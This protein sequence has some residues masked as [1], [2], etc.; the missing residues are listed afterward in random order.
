MKVGK[1][2]IMD[3]VVTVERH[4]KVDHRA[5]RRELDDRAVRVLDV[6]RGVCGVFCKRACPTLQTACRMRW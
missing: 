5:E 1:E 3:L 2:V 4:L 6:L